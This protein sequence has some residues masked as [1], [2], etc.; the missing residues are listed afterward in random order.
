MEKTKYPS[1]ATGFLASNEIW[2]SVY[3]PTTSELSY[4]PLDILALRMPGVVVILNVDYP[5]CSRIGPSCY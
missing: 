2:T 4:P 5:L 1:T 3:S